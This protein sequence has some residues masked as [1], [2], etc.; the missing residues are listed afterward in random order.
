[1]RPLA[2]A[3]LCLLAACGQTSN[4]CSSAAYGAC[5]VQSPA[6]MQQYDE[7]HGCLSAAAPVP[8]LCRSSVINGP[9][10]SASLG[11]G[12]AIAPDG[13]IFVTS[14][15]GAQYVSGAGWRST[16]YP[17]G[18]GPPRPASDV[19]TGEDLG[20]CAIA[21]CSPS[22]D[23][24]PTYYLHVDCG[25]AA[26]NDGGG[27]GCNYN[28]PGLRYVAR[29]RLRDH[30]LGLPDGRLVSECVWLRMHRA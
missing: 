10:Q 13:G 22:C 9:C 11:P 1:M 18:Y 4:P 20:R 24:T 30:R 28:D 12:C 5:N 3:P 6:I 15:P 8:G 26:S 17:M 25:D 16:R 27:G 21:Q 2:A 29:G 14:L 23:G 7:V 19:A